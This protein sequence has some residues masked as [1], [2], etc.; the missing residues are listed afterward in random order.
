[1]PRPSYGNLRSSADVRTHRGLGSALVRRGKDAEFQEL[2][3]YHKEMD[4]LLQQETALR[5]RLRRVQERMTVVEQR[6]NDGLRRVAPATAGSS[7]PKPTT[8]SAPPAPA[9]NEDTPTIRPNGLTFRRIA[10]KY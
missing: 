9:V 8:P 6:M 1:M 3:V 5:A 10:M 7:A 4:R 2:Y